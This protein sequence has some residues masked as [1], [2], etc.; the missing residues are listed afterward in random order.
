MHYEITFCIRALWS[1]S[2][3]SLIVYVA[4]AFLLRQ[5]MWD[6]LRWKWSLQT[7]SDWSHASDVFIF[8][9]FSEMDTSGL[10]RHRHYMWGMNTLLETHNRTTCADQANSSIPLRKQ[11]MPLQTSALGDS[12]P[13]STVMK[14][15]I[16]GQGH[17][18]WRGWIKPAFPCAIDYKTL[19]KM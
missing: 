19:N 13:C 5:R 18:G 1:V 3:K 4:Y 2:E 16:D 11:S 7:K 14:R 6:N 12:C 10:V 15:T 8:K 9:D 17:N